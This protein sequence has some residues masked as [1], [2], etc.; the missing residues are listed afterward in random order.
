KVMTTSSRYY[1]SSNDPEIIELDRIL[2]ALQ[3]NF[4]VSKTKDEHLNT[5]R[6]LIFKYTTEN[7]IKSTELSKLCSVQI[8][9]HVESRRQY[10]NDVLISLQYDIN[11]VNNKINIMITKKLNS[12]DICDIEKD[13]FNFL[14]HDTELRELNNTLL[15][16]TFK[17]NEILRFLQNY[18]EV[19]N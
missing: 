16:Y 7:K 13:I 3:I 5:G 17:R 18:P 10:L 1:V 2:K 9:K 19:S 11:I 14:E 12:K 8:D 6:F 15:T 4:K